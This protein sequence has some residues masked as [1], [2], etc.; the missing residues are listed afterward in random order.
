MTDPKAIDANIDAAMKA[1]DHGVNIPKIYYKRCS[2]LLILSGEEGGIGISA[3]GGR[4]VLLRHK[5]GVWSNPIAMNYGGI[6]AGAVI[7]FAEKDVLVF[8]NPFA[9]TKFLEAK[10][11]LK[12]NVDFG[13]AM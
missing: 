8:L 10:D 1:L 6:G 11:Q 7:G 4:G 3:Q 12:L 2:G 9:M 13:I 5:D